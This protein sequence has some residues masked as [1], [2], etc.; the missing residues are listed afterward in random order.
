MWI[1]ELAMNTATADSKIGSHS[2][3][4]AVMVRLLSLEEVI[5]GA[6]L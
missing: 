5:L 2:E 4:S 3:Y 1:K 6:P